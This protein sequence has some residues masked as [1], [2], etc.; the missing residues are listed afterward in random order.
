MNRKREGRIVEENSEESE[1]EV[2][3]TERPRAARRRGDSDSDS[4]SDGKSSENKETE[5]KE[6][7][8]LVDKG[9]VNI[10]NAFEVD[11]PDVSRTEAYQRAKEHEDWRKIAT[12]IDAGRKIYC[13]RADSVIRNTKDI[14]SQ[15]ARKDNRI[16]KKGEDKETVKES[17]H[18]KGPDDTMGNYSF[19]QTK[20]TLE[21]QEKIS[22]TKFESDEMDPFHNLFSGIFDDGGYKGFLIN[23]IL[24]KED[25]SYV[26]YNEE[27]EE[28]TVT[29]PPVHSITIKSL[30][31]EID[32]L[33]MRRDEINICNDLKLFRGL[34]KD[35]DINRALNQNESDFS[36]AIETSQC[37]LKEDITN[38]YGNKDSK[39][40]F[41]INSDNILEEIEKSQYHH[42]IN[43]PSEEEEYPEVDPSL[44]MIQSPEPVSEL[45]AQISN[46]SINQ[47]DPSMS[48][49]NFDP[50]TREGFDF[51]NFLEPE[52]WSLSKFIRKNE[53]N[54]Q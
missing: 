6:V 24:R 53:G 35:E 14:V 7:L 17:K 29:E 38:I 46:M 15:I 21:R 28:A 25:F 23:N 11:F 1:Y 8:R 22:K 19:Y 45:D 50:S 13:Y 34:F 12:V 16:N 41:G 5:I 51:W 18:R 3:L 39:E 36:L 52:S 33:E 4:D 32:T 20:D 42:D 40:V 9:K 48:I 30:D 31:N 43:L 44:D 49:D 47:P 37:N 10:K 26:M 2:E 54:W 27:I